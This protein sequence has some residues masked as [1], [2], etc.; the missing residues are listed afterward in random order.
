MAEKEELVQRSPGN[1]VVDGSFLRSRPEENSCGTAVLDRSLFE[2]AA[3]VAR[4]C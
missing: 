3:Q 4:S 1:A 2:A